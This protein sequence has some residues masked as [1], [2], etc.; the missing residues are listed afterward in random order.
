MIEQEVREMLNSKVRNAPAL[1]EPP[2]PVL[3]RARV[4]RALNAA[5][6]AAGL[7][8]VV[9]GSLIGV[10]SLESPQ[11]AVPITPLPGVVPW[12]D[13]FELPLNQQPACRAADLVLTAE[14]VTQGTLSFLPRDSNV[15]C[16]L[17]LG[18][19]LR[20][21]DSAGHDVDLRMNPEGEAQGAML[22][23]SGTL[24]TDIQLGFMN[25]C[26]PSGVLRFDVT[27]PNNGGTLSALT[28][29]EPMACYGPGEQ[30]SGTLRFVTGKAARDLGRL[31]ELRV[32]IAG[33]PGS[34]ARGATL[35]YQVHVANP[36]NRVIRF[37]VCPAFF[38]VMVPD[39]R[40]SQDAFA[41]GFD[42]NCPAAPDA[43][44]AHRSLVF[45]MELPIRTDR[46]W[47]PGL[48][49][50]KWRWDEAI[51]SRYLDTATILITE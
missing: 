40:R 32:Q 14:P 29:E 9:V 7:A 31:A 35:H 12:V 23:T 18:L 47:V 25:G 19:A 15:R 43:I 4:R 36:T 22:V 24:T 8:V 27:L 33:L 3:R 26:L 49:Q 13:T 39:F 51:S 11:D 30:L 46:E 21:R 6:L 44:P 34:I 45:A 50:L 5:G 48:A 37:E 10:R 20:I 16:R 1:N 38:Q 2:A 41:R 17:D 28:T 42:L